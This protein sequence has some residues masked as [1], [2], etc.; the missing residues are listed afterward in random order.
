[1]N[2]HIDAALLDTEKQKQ[3]YEW[4]DEQEAAPDRACKA[5]VFRVQLLN[6]C[7]GPR[8]RLPNDPTSQEFHEAYASALSGDLVDRRPNW[9]KKDAPGSIGALF[10][11]KDKR[12]ADAGDT[13]TW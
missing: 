11:L 6:T 4:L 8:T 5:K 12:P 7:V 13:A 9:T 3:A 1:M 2:L 10:V